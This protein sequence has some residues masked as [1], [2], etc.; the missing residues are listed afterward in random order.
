[1]K[2]FVPP[3]VILLCSLAAASL[4]A[5]ATP[6]QV[7]YNG[8][9]YDVTAENLSFNGSAALLQSQVWFGDQSVA[10]FFAETVGGQLGFQNYNP[11][12]SQLA[13]QWGPLFAYDGAPDAWADDGG[14]FQPTSFAGY[15]GDTFTYAVAAAESVPDGGLTLA[16]LGVAV[17]GLA[18]LRRKPVRA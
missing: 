12:P 1:M 3:A 4:T 2:S 16:W 18:V 15:G 10:A 14:N 13:S 9:V 6:V 7:T 11:P 17:A 5:R 8:T